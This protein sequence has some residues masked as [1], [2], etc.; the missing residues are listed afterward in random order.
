MGRTNNIWVL[1][2]YIDEEK[3]KLFKV[4]EFN[5][6]KDIAYCCNKELFEIS[7]FYHN[8]KKPSGL[9]KYIYIYKS[10]I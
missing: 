7:N 6:L 8:I 3:T 1:N 9:F 10:I 4:L 5:T 2:L